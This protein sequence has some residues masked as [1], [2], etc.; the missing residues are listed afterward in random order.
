MSSVPA[1]SLATVASTAQRLAVLLAA[2]VAPSSAW[3]HLAVGSPSSAVLAAA[4]AD[5]ADIADAIAAAAVTFDPLEAGAW[6]GLAAAWAV[7]TEAGAPLAPSLAAYA[8]SLR[9][10]AQTQRD[11]TVAL[12]GPVATARIV[13]VLPFVG[14]FFGF[15]LG[16]DTLGTLLTTAPGWACLAAGG[17]GV[18]TAHRWNRRLVRAARPTDATPGLDLDLTAIA[19]G[20][21]ASLDRA[22]ATVRAAGGVFGVPSR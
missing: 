2:G 18:F 19:V 12:A 15:A 4:G 8:G 1:D 3:R 5:P 21:G 17:L 11:V 14:M 9:S 13:M 7:A 20:G 10:L 6:R 16:F 22:V